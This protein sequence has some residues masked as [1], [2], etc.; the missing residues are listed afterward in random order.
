MKKEDNVRID[1]RPTTGP[2]TARRSSSTNS[3]VQPGNSCGGIIEHVS[4]EIGRYR[5]K[6]VKAAKKV[7]FIIFFFMASPSEFEK[8]RNRE[9]NL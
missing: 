9:L 6:E 3:D 7:G 5:W 2:A 1:E 4:L 8:P